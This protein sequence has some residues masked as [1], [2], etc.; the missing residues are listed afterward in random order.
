[1]KEVGGGRRRGIVRGRGGQARFRL[2][3]S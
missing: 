1:L 2:I 3:M